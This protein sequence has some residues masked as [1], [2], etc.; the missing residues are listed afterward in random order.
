VPDDAIFEYRDAPG[1]LIRRA[2]ELAATCERHG[3]TLPDA[4]VQF[5]LR[6]P[7]VVSAV[8]GARDAAEAASGVERYARNTP[9]ELW[10]DL[11][12]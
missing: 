5:P 2:R 6:H 11:S 8:L 1:D 9:E 10:D 7:A 12:G 3:V 4:A